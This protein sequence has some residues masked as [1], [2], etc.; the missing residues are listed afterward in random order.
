MLVDGRV[1]DKIIKAAKLCGNEAVLEVG[2]GTGVLTQELCK[3]AKHVVSYEVDRKLHLETKERLA[4]PNLELVN[5]DPFK[6]NKLQFDVLISNLPYSRSRD[7]IEWLATQK[8]D[9]A[10]MMVQ[11]EFADKLSAMPGSKNYRA[12]SALSS[13]C[14]SVEKLFSVDRNSFRPKPNVV[15]TVIRIT[16]VNTVQ[17]E[18]KKALNLLFSKRNK[19]ASVITSKGGL[20]VDFGDRRIDQLTPTELII[21]SE[22]ISNVRSI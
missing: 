13:Y 22:S 10:I 3:V 8:F 6:L 12:I 17:K 7:A 19:K 20:G 1:V 11:A 16:W 2:T 4:F 18:T 5:E 14:F 21:I 15:S 9:M